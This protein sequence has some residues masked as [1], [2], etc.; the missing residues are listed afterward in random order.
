MKYTI[1]PLLSFTLLPAAQ[2]LQET[3]SY[4]FV[5][6]FFITNKPRIVA[7]NNADGPPI[8]F[9]DNKNIYTFDPEN[10]QVIRVKETKNKSI[11]YPFY[12]EGKA[13]YDTESKYN[14]AKQQLVIMSD[15]STHDLT[16]MNSF[17]QIS[18]KGVIVA[19]QQAVMI[20]K[21]IDSLPKKL[22]CRECYPEEPIVD[23]NYLES[24]EKNR[25]LLFKG[26]ICSSCV[27]AITYC[28]AKQFLAIAYKRKDFDSEGI[29]NWVKIFAIGDNQAKIIETIKF[30]NPVLSIA[31]DE[32]GNKILIG[33]ENKKIYEYHFGLR[34]FI[35]KVKDL[36]PVA[37]LIG[38]GLL[39]LR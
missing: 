29:R 31:F 25:K 4:Q 30:L 18:Q 20:N 28:P 23:S 35:D 22:K 17:S 5:H 10:K 9:A 6:E 36:M 7:Y 15:N 39:M 33:L 3:G 34:S 38:F 11:Q 32:S 21:K 24:L 16:T 1:I 26:D 19:D 12:S 14:P 13:L 8:A 2:E 37:L 27:Q